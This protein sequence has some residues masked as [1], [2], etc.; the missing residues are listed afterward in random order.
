MNVWKNIGM[1]FQDKNG[2]FV[3][4]DDPKFDP[5]FDFIESHGKKL[6]GHIGEPRHCWLPVEKMLASSNCEYY[7]E[8]PQYH[9]YLHPEFPAYED[10]IKAYECM[11]E[12]HPT[13]RYMGCHLASLEWSLEELARR[14][15]RFPN[16][17]VD[18]AARIDDLQILERE[19]VR[20]FFI[21]YQDRIL[22][23]TDLSIKEKPDPKAYT[24]HMHQTWLQDW[25][26]F[27]TDSIITI[28][29]IEKPVRGLDLPASVLRKISRV[30]AQKWYKRIYL[31]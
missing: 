20:Q 17:A 15:D 30:N 8:Q 9:I 10:H 12:K 19:E 5:I 21:K 13:I 16:M 26:Y 25:V 18:L 2:H 4:I 24:E 28:S 7:E 3:M 22:Y 23:G 6:T 1:Q 14:L 31:S 27:A 11:L 29:G